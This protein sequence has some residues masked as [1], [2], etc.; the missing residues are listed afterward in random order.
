M[1]SQLL[2]LTATV[3]LGLM[4]VSPLRLDGS[5]NKAVFTSADA[6]WA[7]AD[8]AASATVRPSSTPPSARCAPE[9]LAKLGV[10]RESIDPNTFQLQPQPPPRTEPPPVEPSRLSSAC[11][12]AARSAAFSSNCMVGSARIA[13]CS[14]RTVAHPALASSSDAP[15]KSPRAFGTTCTSRCFIVDRSSEIGPQ[16]SDV[17]LYVLIGVFR[18]QHHVRGFEPE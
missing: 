6:T 18:V 2:G 15:S 14:G 17:R 1:V 11:S 3:A 7:R 9:W 13:L 10:I 5:T 12:N 16:A 8:V 4:T